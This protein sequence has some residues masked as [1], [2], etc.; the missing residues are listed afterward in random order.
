[1][2]N[3]NKNTKTYKIDWP[4]YKPLDEWLK[5]QPT[6]TWKETFEKDGYLVVHGLIDKDF[7]EIYKD[8]YMKLLNGEIDTRRHR[9]DL[10]CNEPQKTQVENICQIMWPHLYVPSLMEG[11]LSE[12]V[13]AINKIII[14]PDAAFDFNML[15]S[16]APKTETATPWHQDE[17]YWPD[18]PDKRASTC[19]VALDQ[20]TVDNGCMWFVPGSHKLPLRK[21][22]P[23]CKGAHVLQCECTEDEGKPEPLPPGSCTLHSGHTLHYSRGNS[24]NGYR[25]AFIINYRPEAM[26]EWERERNFAHGKEGLDETKRDD[27]VIIR[28][29]VNN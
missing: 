10:G 16:K 14:G 22:W 19:W 24:T 28:R 5:G 25:R 23:A 20:S 15:I 18:M 9:Q 11:P 7:V 4:K 6:E 26:V 29:E 8:V 17:S 1:M 21:H 2:S 27:V 13:Q 12:R 3:E